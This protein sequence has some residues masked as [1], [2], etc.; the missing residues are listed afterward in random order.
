[1]GN[2][3]NIIGVGPQ[4]SLAQIILNLCLSIILGLGIAFVY[5]RTHR[6]ASYSQSF[7]L[8][9]VLVTIVAATAIMVIGQSLTRAFGLIGAFS[10]IRFRTA[11]KDARD[12]AFVFFSLVEGL[13]AGTGSFMIALVAFLLFTI[14]VIFLTKGQF[15]KFS[16]FEYLLSFYTSTKTKGKA[17]YLKL[18]EIFLSE[19]LLISYRSTVKKSEVLATYNIRLKDDNQ[20][21]DF[22]DKLRKSGASQIELISSQSDIDY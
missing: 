1:M 3:L 22:I 14:L 6:G 10:V 16:S 9:I 20:V 2:P 8:A 7:V 18:F 5:K 17:P 13:A 12:V 4:Y 15:G 19:Y 21:K 11:I